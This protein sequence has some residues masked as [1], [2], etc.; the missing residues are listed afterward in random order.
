MFHLFNIHVIQMILNKL[1]TGIEVAGVEFIW[2]IPAER[3]KFPS[4]LD[5]SV[6]EC[7]TKQHWLPLW[8]VRD[9][10]EVLGYVS[11][12]SL[13]ACLDTLRRLIGELDRH[14]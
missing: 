10:Q 13:E 7:D 4:F 3:S 12:A 5:Y 9:L 11:I 14:L 6:K 1:N 2:D 8:H